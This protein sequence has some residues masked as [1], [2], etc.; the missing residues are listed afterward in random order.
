L[1]ILPVAAVSPV[2]PLKISAGGRY[3]VDQNNTPFLL[4]GD[5]PHSLIVNLS[6]TNAAFY[7]ADRATNGFNSLWVEL[8]CV[9]YTGGRQDG[10]LLDGTLP[11]TNTITSTTNYDLTTPNEAYFAY[12][13][14]IIRMAATNGIQV[15]LDPLDTGGMLTTA[16][17]N[18]TINC[19]VY[20]QYLG[21]RYKNIPNILWISGNDFQTWSNSANDAVITAIASGIKDNDTNHLQTVE[22]NYLLSSS[23]DDTNWASIVGLNGAYTY[24][25][26]YD[27][28]LH[29]YRQSTN[30]PVFM[31]EANYEF[32]ALVAGEPVTTT[33][34]LR[35]QEYWTLL[36]GGAGQMYG[37]HYI[38]PFLSGWQA[39]LDTP[40][41]VEMRYVRALFA[42][43]TW[44]NL[45]PD[46]NHTVVTAGYGTYSSSGYVA[47]NNYLAVARTVD[48]S[49]VLVYTPVL[50]QFS[51]NMSQMS[52]PAV[53]RW[54][55]PSSGGYIPI[56]GSPF[57]NT[58]TQNFTPPG[59]NADGDGGWVL[60]L[61]TSPPTVPVQPSLVQQNYATPQTP[62]SQVAVGYPF[63]Q[64]Q[65]DL[66]ILAIGWSDTSASISVVSDSAG[67]VYQV[68][69]PTYRSNGM[70][71]AIYYATN[72]TG[73]A[74]TVTALFNQNAAFVDFRAAEFSGLSQSNVF[75]AG[76]SAGGS[77]TSAN[78]GPVTTTLTNDLIFGAGLTSGAFT[79]AGAGFAGFITVPDSDI[80]ED[81]TAATL[82]TYAAT[83]S[84]N[85]PSQWLMQVAAFKAAVL[86]PVVTNPITITLSNGEFVIH[87]N[88][89]LGQI[90]SLQNTT[91]LTSGSWSPIVT[92]IVGT[93]NS[94]G[95][96]DTNTLSRGQRFYRASWTLAPTGYTINVSAGSGGS[97]N[98]NGSFVVSAGTNQT[99]IAGPNAS[100]VVSE[101]LLDGSVV[102]TGGT[103]YTLNDIQASHSVQVTFTYIPNQYTISA[104]AVSGGS[105]SP[106][107]SFE[108]N[109]G[110]NEIF[111]AAPNLNFVVNQWL[112]DG[113]VV[114]KGGTNYTLYDIQA[115]HIVQVTFNLS[116]VIIS[117]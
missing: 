113:S 20:G 86:D 48:G 11:F 36:S 97:I 61:E 109:A 31:E 90:Y 99:F 5:S 34:V 112:L 8:L 76:S 93:G 104:S 73:G 44:Y 98:P 92:N 12:V 66:N 32:E 88:T 114:Q 18:G 40:G 49:L 70:S 63:A 79:E 59:N 15:M 21:N 65:G 4:I 42:P 57:S 68:A 19:R 58:G 35:K 51:V 10:S 26:T 39:N 53:A 72:I 16:L 56:S 106:K 91:N 3:L 6:E 115:S 45:V 25:P 29:A 64:I 80:I 101:W 77:G 55:D 81:T 28:V 107:G 105:V 110:I 67:N 24:Y 1:L 33:P 9:P 22:L 17:A 2:Y 100:Y 78:S 62:Q 71:Q 84:L 50:G 103:S 41:A 94:V 13:D 60:A 117:H 74:N 14:Q 89:A 47:N 52:G 54:Y 27:E 43:R 46:T 7:L 23:L 82:G 85:S 37:N 96:V 30:I 102:Q 69:V 108:V 75:A 111:T 95:I 83:A 116:L 87:F 38:W